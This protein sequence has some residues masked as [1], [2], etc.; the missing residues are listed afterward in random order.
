[1]FTLETKD[2][3]QCKAEFHDIYLD[4]QYWVEGEELLGCS[5][6]QGNEPIVGGNPK[7]DLYYCP[8]ADE[9]SRVY[10][11]K[12]DVVIFFPTD[13]HRPGGVGMVGASPARKWWSRCA[14]PCLEVRDAY[15]CAWGWRH[16]MPVRMPVI[17]QESCGLGWRAS[18]KIRGAAP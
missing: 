5:E 18:G 10:A 12:G 14:L 3:T 16:G 6:R 7:D 15:R 13:I 9:E 4:V 11:R 17:R 8:V 2:I 1:V